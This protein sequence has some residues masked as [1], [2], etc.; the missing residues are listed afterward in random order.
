[1]YYYLLYVEMMFIKKKTL[2]SVTSYH[3][4]YSV[5]RNFMCLK[6]SVTVALHS[7][8][9]WALNS[10]RHIYSML[11]GELLIT[12]LLRIHHDQ[13]NTIQWPIQLP[14]NNTFPQQYFQCFFNHIQWQHLS[15]SDLRNRGKFPQPCSDSH[16][17][18]SAN[19]HACA[20][21][22]ERKRA[23]CSETLWLSLI[24]PTD[25]LKA[26]HWSLFTSLM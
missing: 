15:K 14:H 13:Y 1:M 7:F 10:D 3:D 4:H 9:N 12:C 8:F 24:F 2:Q 25:V 21:E 19:T 17:T 22:R 20:R 11:P 23:K 18:H 6:S 5:R 26:E 16:S